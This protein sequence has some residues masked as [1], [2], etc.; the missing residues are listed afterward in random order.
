MAPLTLTPKE[1][2][3]RTFRREPIDT[4]AFFS[5]MGMVVMPAIQKLGYRFSQIHKDAE[6]MARSAIESSRMFG[7]DSVVIPFDM[8]MESEAIGNTISLYENSKDIL[9]PTI[10]QKMWSTMDQVNI[11]SN[12]ME[13]GRLPLLTKAIGIIKKKPRSCRSA[14]GNWGPSPRRD[15][16]WSWISCL[17]AYSRK[18]P[19]WMPRWTS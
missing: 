8:T 14:S 16:S 5:G 11:P 18:R 4:M 10:P 19:R 2:V 13:L 12:I 7:F 17:R 15:R 1:R 3:M 9:Y 6:K